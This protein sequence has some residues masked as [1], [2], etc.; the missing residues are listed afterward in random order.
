[1]PG[2]NLCI[3][4]ERRLTRFIRESQKVL[5]QIEQRTPEVKAKTDTQ[6]D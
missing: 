1:M 2:K 3:S 5:Q 4:T 6:T